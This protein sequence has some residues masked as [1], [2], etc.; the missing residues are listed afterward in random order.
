MT[1][2]LLQGTYLGV[3]TSKGLLQVWDVAATPPRRVHS[4][5]THQARVGCV[6]WNGELVSTGSRD[7]SIAVRDLR[8]PDTPFAAVRRLHSHK[9]EVCAHS[10]SWHKLR[11]L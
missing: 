5:L 6:A 10:R 2:I 1:C 9:Q 3:G 4:L 11:N 7:R 8:Q